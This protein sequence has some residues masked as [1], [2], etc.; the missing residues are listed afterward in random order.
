MEIGFCPWCK[1]EERGFL[2]GTGDYHLVRCVGC[3]LVYKGASREESELS[4]NAALYDEE[5]IARR[6]WGKGRLEQVARR[7][8]RVLGECVPGGGRILEVGCGT[9]EFLA[10]AQ[11]GGYEVAA[12][13]MS[14]VLAE[15]VGGELGVDC[16]C[17][18]LEEFEGGGGEYDAVAA[19]DVIEHVVD[20]A[21]LVGEMMKRLKPGGT[22][23]LEMPN[24]RCWERALWGH[25]W[26]MVNIRDHVNFFTAES[27]FCEAEKLG[28]KTEWV[29]TYEVYWEGV[30]AGV[31][32]VLNWNR[33]GKYDQEKKFGHITSPGGQELA[34][35]DLTPNVRDGAY[36]RRAFWGQQLPAG[37]AWLFQWLTY[38]VRW[39]QAVN[40][41]G[42]ELSVMAKKTMSIGKA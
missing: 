38:P 40:G 6:G 12:V 34:R 11:R 10:A 1:E 18:R 23:F 42:T 3:G 5:L 28:L 26:N 33:I 31:F 29:R 16:F 13:E 32:G 27:W 8:V 17:G 24:W 37:G 39:V 2:W 30:F 20:P 4:V 9:G 14:R 41:R 36:K 7:R 19:F 35:H 22:L 21:G 25:R 15:Y